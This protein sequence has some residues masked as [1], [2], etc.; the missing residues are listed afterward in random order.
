VPAYVLQV[1]SRGRSMIAISSREEIE[2][3]AASFN[4]SD[5]DPVVPG[6]VEK[7]SLGLAPHSAP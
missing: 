3:I 4:P 6:R 1:T 2:R 7:I 5:L